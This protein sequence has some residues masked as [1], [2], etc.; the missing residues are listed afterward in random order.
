VN[1][2][3]VAG[4]IVAVQEQRFRLRTDGGQVLLLTLDRR[5]PLD[6]ATLAGLHRRGT[7]VRVDF[8]G[9][10]N[11]KSGLAHAIHEASDE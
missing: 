10:P 9:E 6:G 2:V 1:P 5:A 8:S 4:R 3:Q 7:Q 11:L